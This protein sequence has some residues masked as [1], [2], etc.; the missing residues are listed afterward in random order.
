M[1]PG[2]SSEDGTPQ[3]V[4][5]ID[6]LERSYEM[7]IADASKLATIKSFLETERD[8][9]LVGLSGNVAIGLKTR[10]DMFIT[11]IGGAFGD[12]F[13]GMNAQRVQNY[14]KV[15]EDAID[16]T[17]GQVADEDVVQ[18]SALD[19]TIASDAGVVGG[20][21]SRKTRKHKKSGRKS[22]SRNSSASHRRT[23]KH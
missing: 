23:R 16:L 18:P 3:V 21:H 4:S 5:G 12:L 11:K 14:R 15:L 1:D 6:F 7:A 20:K 17:R 22:S 9:A 2:P 8:K 19:T 10:F 13:T